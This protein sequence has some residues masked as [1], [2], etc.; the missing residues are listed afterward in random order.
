MATLLWNSARGPAT[1]TINAAGQK[2]YTSARDNPGI[3]IAR[4]YRKHNKALKKAEKRERMQH[5]RLKE[6]LGDSELTNV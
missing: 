6:L 2:G 4:R 1:W 5:R 3:V